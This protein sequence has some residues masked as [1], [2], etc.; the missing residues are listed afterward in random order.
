MVYLLKPV[1]CPYDPEEPMPTPLGFTIE[2]WGGFPTYTL[3]YQLEFKPLPAAA[4]PNRM[5]A[6]GNR[7]MPDFF[8]TEKSLFFVS[9]R[10][11]SVLEQYALGQV[12]FIEVELTM[13][14]DKE[15]ADAYYF[16]NVL[17][18]SQLTNWE[19]TP[20]RKRRSY[21]WN[22]PPETWVMNSPQS[23][24]VA[25]WH[26]TH[27]IVDGERFCGD[28]TVVFVTDEFGNALDAAFPGQCRL[29]HIREIRAPD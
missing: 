15:P 17:G 18:R 19:L 21:F 4:V 10:F 24:H 5:H 14:A 1:N 6:G 3:N 13:S 26:E 16:I 7:P 29:E 25:I 27:R 8:R 22:G 23:D 11:R 28:G 9:S 20:K 2:P 12:E